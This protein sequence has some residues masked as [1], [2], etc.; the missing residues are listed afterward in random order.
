MS[1]SAPE[2]TYIAWLG[3]QDLAIHGSPAE[4]FRDH[5]GVVLNDGAT[6]GAGS[7]RFVRFVFTTP[8]PIMKQAVEQMAEALVRRN[9]NVAAPLQASQGDESV[10][11]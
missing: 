5:A 10:V 7:E 11:G 4:F 8:R 6:C 2:G 1:Y 9:G 3:A